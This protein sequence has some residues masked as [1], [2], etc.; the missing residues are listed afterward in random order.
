MNRFSVVKRGVTKGYSI[1]KREE[2]RKYLLLIASNNNYI[3][4]Q[5]SDIWLG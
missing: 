2:G 5:Y 4:S 1:Y 3:F